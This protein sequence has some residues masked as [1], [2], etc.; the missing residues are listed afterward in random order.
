MIARIPYF[1]RILAVLLVQLFALGWMV[2]D[3]AKILE[4]GTE[5]RLPARPVDPRD[6]FRG[7]YVRLGYD[8]SQLRLPLLGGANDFKRDDPVFLLARRGDDSHIEPLSVHREPPAAA[9]GQVVL[10]GRVTSRAENS[11]TAI[12]SDQP[13]CPRPC[14]SLAVAWGLESYFVPKEEALR[15][16]KLRNLDRLEILASVSTDGRAAIKGLIIDSQLVYEEPLF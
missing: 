8:I 16:E 12:G 5:I 3:R 1:A 2:A 7:H 9:P 10:A 6:L 11:P 15:L 14:P 13:P 4:N